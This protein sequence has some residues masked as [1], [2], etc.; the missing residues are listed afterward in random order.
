M[1]NRIQLYCKKGGFLFLFL[2]IALILNHRTGYITLIGIFSLLVLSLVTMR[3]KVDINSFAILAYS[4][5][6]VLLSTFNGFSY[7]LS[8]YVLYLVAPFVFYQFGRELVLRMRTSEYVLIAWLIIVIC[9]SIDVFLTTISNIRETGILTDSDRSFYLTGSNAIQMSATVVGLSMNIGMIGLPMLF[10]VKGKLLRLSFFTLFIL[11]LITTVSLLN[12]TAIVVAVSVFLIILLYKYKRNLKTF[13]LLLSI[14]IGIIFMLMHWGFISSD[15]I[16]LY[17]ERNVDIATFGSRTERWSNALEYLITRPLGWA[18]SIGS[19]YVHN[20]WL[21][22]ARVSGIIPF[23][24]LAYITLDSMITAFI[25]LR[26]NETQLS[27]MLVGLNICF[28]ASC[29]VEPVY[30]GTHMLLYFMLWG[31]TKAFAERELLHTC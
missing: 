8:S 10:V 27:Y 18:D 15:I 20:M 26:K 14:L 31:T 30:G 19:Y 13:L 28:F 6:F 12:R 11:S 23:I 2:C 4:V 5:M 29:F 24:L 3:K 9:Y 1:I 22:V 21:D 17:N 7:S 25:T 16:E